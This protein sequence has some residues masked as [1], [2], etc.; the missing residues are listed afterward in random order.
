MVGFHPD[1]IF[2]TAAGP[3]IDVNVGVVKVVG[4]FKRAIFARH[5]I[6]HPVIYP[7]VF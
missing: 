7:A 4:F 2:V 1:A 6:R 5:G 3:R